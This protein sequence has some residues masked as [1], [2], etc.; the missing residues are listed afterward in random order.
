MHDSN[1][2]N[3]APLFNESAKSRFKDASCFCEHLCNT[4]L[5]ESEADVRDNLDSLI[6]EVHDWLDA[7]GYKM[8]RV[9]M[10]LMLKKNTGSFRDD[11]ITPQVLHELTQAI[12]FISLIED[13]I[14]IDDPEIVLSL[15]FVHDLGENHNIRPE[16]LEKHFNENGVPSGKRMERLL[17]GFGAISKYYG[18]KERMAFNKEKIRNEGESRYQRRVRENY[19]ASIAKFMD[20][21]QNVETLVGVR[22]T[23]KINFEIGKAARYYAKHLVAEMR[24]TFPENAR[25]YTIM[26]KLLKAQLFVSR[27]YTITDGDPLPENDVILLRM[28][29]KGFSFM[30]KGLHPLLV[31]AE[32][33]RKALPDIYTKPGSN[34]NNHEPV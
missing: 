3:S 13:G 10:D 9:A 2:L 28:P 11:E 23:N 8:A 29:R 18:E 20:R 22:D 6:G 25:F 21:P 34:D 32:R 19:D 27:H 31:I 15:I 24:E 4:G 14:I 7:K 1:M 17:K 33:I 30:P 12:W 26:N 16:A 5:Y